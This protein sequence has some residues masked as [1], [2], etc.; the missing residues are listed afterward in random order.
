VS[1]SFAIED[2]GGRGLLTA[3]PAVAAARHADWFAGA[4]ALGREPS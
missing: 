3:T 1:A 4:E 2:W